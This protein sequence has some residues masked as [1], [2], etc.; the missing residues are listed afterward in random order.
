MTAERESDKN[1]PEEQ[2]EL[3]A[4]EAARCPGE[5]DDSIEK[6]DDGPLDFDGDGSGAAAD[7]ASQTANKVC[8]ENGITPYGL[9]GSG[10][11]TDDAIYN[12]V[13]KL[14][15]RGGLNQYDV[16]KMRVL[17]AW[18][19]AKLV[20]DPLFQ[21]VIDSMLFDALLGLRR[22]NASQ[23]KALRYFRS[24][25]KVAAGTR[26]KPEDPIKKLLGGKDPIEVQTQEEPAA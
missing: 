8:A 12:L 26:P 2:A 22:L 6:D 4:L 17:P 14:N 24:E 10:R 25:S 19:K 18:V 20:R 21:E 9:P 3:D 7:I 23:W 1:T 16:D 13:R 11:Y 15:R 5:D